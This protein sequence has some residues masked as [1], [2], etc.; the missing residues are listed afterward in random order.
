MGFSY[1]DKFTYLNTF[2]MELAQRCLDDG[3]STVLVYTLLL[4]LQTS[5]VLLCVM[6]CHVFTGQVAS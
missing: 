6:F 5:T 1:P 3:G 4:W 2:M